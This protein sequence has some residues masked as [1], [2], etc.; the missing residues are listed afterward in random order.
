MSRTRRKR[1][2]R[3]SISAG[4]LRQRAD[5]LSHSG[6][7]AGIALP[8]PLWDRGGG[9]VDAAEAAARGAGAELQAA[10]QRLAREVLATV[11]AVRQTDAQVSALRTSLGS[12]AA[13]ALKA[14]ETAYAEGE[15]ALIEWLDAVRAY[16]E[17][18]A[19]FAAVLAESF[20]Q[21]AALERVLG[22]TLLR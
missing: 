10:R 8:L 14:A 20:T 7:V 6:F 12:E 22:V 3:P 21:R 5:D 17:A 1:V 4:Y 11:E 18:E 13:A 9:A 2:Q 15:I 16:Q 19:A